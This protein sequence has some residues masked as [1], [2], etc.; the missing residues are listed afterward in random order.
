MTE[1]EQH[2]Q[3]V[4]RAIGYI[5][6]HAQMQPS[7]K[8]I[9]QAVGL[10]EYHL[11]RIFTRWAGVSP[12]RFLQFLTKQRA[13]QAL[14]ESGDILNAA[15]D[16]GL[17]GPSRLHDLMISCEAMS[18]GEIKALGKDLVIG[19]GY[20]GSPFG[21]ILVGWTPRGICYLS[22]IDEDAQQR[23]GEFKQQWPY[24]SFRQN[25]SEAL[26][27][28][29]RIFGSHNNGGKV[30]LM[31]QGT[32]FQLKVWEALLKTKPGQLVSYAGLA[33]LAGSPKAQ[34][35]VGTTLANNNIGWL[36]PCHRVIRGTGE[37]GN[38]RWGAERKLAMQ[39]WEAG[40]YRR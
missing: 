39:G 36:I 19:F 40:H 13:L 33:E 9:A 35:A 25:D 22:F 5:Q 6:Q 10:S 3:Y 21:T 26:A 16:S 32:N 2:Y 15:L 7:L 14:K 28:S 27:I 38:Y 4:A 20:A 31:I 8:Q 12:K 11:Q 23:E 29:D 1:S 24:A 37:F 30:H 17:S 18:P 34:R